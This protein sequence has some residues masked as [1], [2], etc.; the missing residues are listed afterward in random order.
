VRLLYRAILALAW[1]I[2]AGILAALAWWWMRRLPPAMPRI[3]LYLLLALGVGP[4]LIVNVALKDHWGRAR[5]SQIATF[6]GDKHFTPA[7]QPTDQCDHNCSF[8]AGHAAMGFYLVSFAFLLRDPKR[9]RRTEAAALA[10]GAA[11]GL[12]RMAQ[13]GHFLSDVVFSGLIVYGTS[14][15]L[16]WAIFGPKS[17]AAA[18]LSPSEAEER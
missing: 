13:G 17:G 3:A 4:G 10:F 16:H 7:L 2:V 8:S 5:P 18:R 1:V 6:G 9:R 11:A 14:A 15:A 12:A